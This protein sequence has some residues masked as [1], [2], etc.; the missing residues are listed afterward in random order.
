MKVSKDCKQNK[1]LYAYPFRTQ[2][3]TP[4]PPSSIQGIDFFV[5]LPTDNDKWRPGTRQASAVMEVALNVGLSLDLLMAQAK[6]LGER[7]YWG[8]NAP[9]AVNILMA[10]GSFLRGNTMLLLE[11]VKEWDIRVTV[12]AVN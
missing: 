4:A 5:F 8:R 1:N 12:I 3:D 10:F 2:T 7:R 6:V 11:V 9:R